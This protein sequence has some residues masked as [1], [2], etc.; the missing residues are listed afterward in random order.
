MSRI[1]RCVV[2]GDGL[3]S[4]ARVFDDL[5][6]DETPR[7]GDTVVT[8]ASAESFTVVRVVHYAGASAAASTCTVVMK[9]N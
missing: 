2:D 1:I 4:R 8:P 3:G 9:P 6:F 7:T 5:Y